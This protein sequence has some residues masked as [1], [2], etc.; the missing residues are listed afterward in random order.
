MEKNEIKNTWKNE[1]EKIG[2][3]LD[4]LRNMLSDYLLKRIKFVTKTKYESLT[5]ENIIFDTERT[6]IKT[7]CKHKKL[8]DECSFCFKKFYDTKK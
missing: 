8:I 3:L 7:K 5:I 6:I 2:E 1:D 4:S